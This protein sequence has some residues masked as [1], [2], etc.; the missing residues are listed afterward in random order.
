MKNMLQIKFVLEVNF[1]LTFGQ[2]VF[3]S[4]YSGRMMYS[5]NCVLW[6]N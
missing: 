6:V 2:E 3:P 5:Q 4:W 1:D